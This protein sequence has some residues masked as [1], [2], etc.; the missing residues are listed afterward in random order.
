MHKI[1]LI[2]LENYP[3][4]ANEAKEHW[5]IFGDGREIIIHIDDSCIL[6]EWKYIY[7]NSRNPNI[8]HN[9]LKL[10]ILFTYGG[11]CF[12]SRVRTLQNLDKTEEECHTGDDKIFV[13]FPGKFPIN[14]LSD[15]LYF[16]TNVTGKNKIINDITEILSR[17]NPPFSFNVLLNEVLRKNKDSFC[18]GPYNKY[19]YISSN[20]ETRVF[21]PNNDYQHFLT[22]VRIVRLDKPTIKK[23][24][25]IEDKKILIEGMKISDM[26]W[27]MALKYSKAI[28]KWSLAGFPVRNQEDIKHI[29]NDI[30][31]PCEYHIN[32]KCKKCGCRISES[33]IALKNKIKIGTEHCPLKPNKW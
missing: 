27:Q 1:H 28:L 24:L 11:W 7:N 15:I 20:P 22:D 29:Y 2:E 33:T 16:G 10:S 21:N 23:E 12:D 5:E 13:T 25:S 8:R 19:S 18:W 9:L 4:L 6:E 26:S 31:L 32:G 14:P 30:C 3:K 17:P